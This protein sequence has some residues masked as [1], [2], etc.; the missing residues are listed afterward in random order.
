MDNIEIIYIG[1]I[2]YLKRGYWWFDISLITKN[3]FFIE[4]NFIITMSM[5]RHVIQMEGLKVHIFYY[6]I[7][8]NAEHVTV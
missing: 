3:Y 4:K 1:A 5:T 8:W 6:K 7:V 2:N